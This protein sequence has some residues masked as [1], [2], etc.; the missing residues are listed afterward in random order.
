MDINNHLA[1][2]LDSEQEKIQKLYPH[3]FERFA[4]DG[5]EFNIYVGQSITP[6]K[7][8]NDLFLQNMRLWQLRVLA[9]GARQLHDQLEPGMETTQLI[10]VYNMPIAI[11]F[12]TEE[13][14][15]DVDHIEHTRYEII[16]KRIDKAYIR[17]TNERLTEP[18]TIAIVYL[19]DNDI[20]EYYRYI[21]YLT[22]EGLLEGTPETLELEELQGVNGLKALR[23]KIKMEKL[24]KEGAKTR[25]SSK[26]V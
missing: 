18:G 2:L 10:L 11:R 4:T 3:Y 5:I 8:F 16:K 1:V 7:N 14:K 12:R 25:A 23:I 21:N 9:L 24:N 22:K 15:F 17:N 13:R 26:A 6:A 20:E 19:A